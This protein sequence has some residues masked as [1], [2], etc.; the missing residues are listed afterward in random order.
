M[1]RSPHARAHG[2]SRTPD[3]ALASASYLMAL[4]PLLVVYVLAQRWI[5]GGVTR[6]AVKGVPHVVPPRGP[7]QHRHRSAARSIAVSQA[8]G[9]G[10]LQQVASSARLTMLEDSPDCH[11][12]TLHSRCGD[13]LRP[14]NRPGVRAR[15]AVVEP[16]HDLHSAGPALS[17]QRREDPRAVLPPRPLGA[18][19]GVPGRRPARRPRGRWR[20]RAGVR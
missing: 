2:A 20:T 11:G 16:N 17:P 19:G 5:I 6:G 4:T 14:S 1:V 10:A 7:C 9:T 8:A 15:L 18:R 12:P 3:Y 13:R